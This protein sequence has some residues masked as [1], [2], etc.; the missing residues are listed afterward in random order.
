MP[1]NSEMPSSLQKLLRLKALE[2]TPEERLERLSSRIRARIEAEK[3]LAETSR[4]SLFRSSWF[5]AIERLVPLA[6]VGVVL[7]A[8]FW[9]PDLNEVI[10][11]ESADRPDMTHQLADAPVPTAPQTERLFGE[12]LSDPKSKTV[13]RKFPFDESE[14]L[15][16]AENTWTTPAMK[17]RNE[18]GLFPP[19]PYLGVPTVSEEQTQ[20]VNHQGP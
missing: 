10:E 19:P 3:V 14:A 17:Q 6:A 5:P 9:V 12:N 4:W 16:V 15:P 1:H 7:I 20:P 8:L 2:V 11:N 18:T 13:I